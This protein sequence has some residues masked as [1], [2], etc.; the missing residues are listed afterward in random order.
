MREKKFGKL[1]LTWLLAATMVLTL[2][3]VSMLAMDAPGE[4]E[5]GEVV[6]APVAGVEE[7]EAAPVEATPM[8][9]ATPAAADTPIAVPTDKLFF[10][11]ANGV[12]TGI[13]ADWLA[14]NKDKP[15][16]VTI[17][18][19]ING[20]PVTSI[21]QNAFNGKKVVAV[22]FS[23][24][25][26][27][28][29]I[30]N[31]AFM[32]SPV[33]SV[34]LSNTQVTVIGKFAFGDCK[35]LETF[36]FSNTLTSLG[37]SD[38]ASVFTD[39][40]SLK[41]MRLAGSPE[42]VVFELPEGL[43][44]IGYQ[45]FK[46]C[47]ADGVDAKVIIPASVAT[48][49]EGAFYDEHITQIIFKKIVDP[50]KSEDY[51]GYANSAI[52][53]PSGCDRI[54]V[55][56]DN[57]CF[58]AYSTQVGYGSKLQ[59]ICTY[60]IKI[61]FSP[62]GK[63]EQHL[64]HALLG[65][66]Y[67]PATKLWDF[68]NSY[69]LP[70]TNGATSGNERPGYE[71]VGGWKLRSSYQVLNENEKL[72]AKDNPS[73][74]ATV[75]GEYKLANPTISYLVDG[76]TENVDANQPFTVTIGDGKEH[77]IGIQVDHPLLKENQGTDEDYV[78]FEYYWFDEV[79]LGDG[80]NTLNGP[81]STEE[82]KR[83]SAATSN[84]EIQYVD[85]KHNTI[86]IA[87]TEHARYEGSS[88]EGYNDYYLVVV[89]GY[90]V[91]N[92]K[93][94]DTPFYLSANNG[95]GVG[96]ANATH[97]PHLLQVKVDE[98][99]VI[100]ATADE[101]G[102]IAP[103]GD[104]A[105]PKG[106]S[107]TF[108]IT[109]DSGYHIKDVLVD[110]KSVGAVS[111]Y[112]FENVVDNHTIH[113]TF[114]RKHTPTPSTPTVEIPDDDALGLNTTD[115]F[116]YIVGYGNGEVRPQNNITRA[117]VATIFFRLLTD[118]VRDE[119]LTKTNRYS[120]VAATS[121]YNTAVSTL[122]SMGIITGYPDGTFRP[123][124]AITRAEFAAI[125]ARFDN[126]GDKTAA[127]FS[128]IATHWAKDEI[129]IAY[130]NGWITGYPDGTFG[131]QRDITRAETMTLVNRVLNRQPETEDDLLPN[132][133][134]W[135]DNANPKAWYYLAV[136]EATNSHYYEFK[137]NSQYEKWTALRETRDWQALEQ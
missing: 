121:W 119:N 10:D 132:M 64:N 53:P 107:K 109:P 98:V 94:A 78:Y 27:L 25:T 83:F 13:D 35:S 17:P 24:A 32:H 6:L 66:T 113:A 124:A 68:N 22:D 89:F 46:N 86:P 117:E 126:D 14:N 37:N 75:S 43:T 65:W 44:T 79:S 19:E 80:K 34:D 48:L 49:G 69:K 59:K 110:G 123:N 128:D 31:Q 114:A 71:Y 39:C 97:G 36:I 77:S 72:E 108:T 16:S 28:E 131:P 42:G 100:T 54:I 118:D 120:D 9:L 61:T 129:S 90:H 102:K 56:S 45:C 106:E 8:L 50:W 67:N 76:K 105:V 137:T 26:N 112:T 73:D 122:S 99:R 92:G 11:K 52:T 15:L 84:V 135:T 111:T 116:A 93:K 62:L 115:H 33:A 12:I 87:K 136:Q 82:Q 125:A 29:K 2:L 81:R 40:R 58:A 4:A 51:S 23:N 103:T 70:D 3:P 85:G 5:D 57:K 60:P 20:T 63:Q 133:T 95:I 88:Y 130:N 41:V 134:V 127:K 1:F 55:L 21:G 91:V 38:G 30:D 96:N 74:R 18:A 7:E 47:F 104:V 101:H